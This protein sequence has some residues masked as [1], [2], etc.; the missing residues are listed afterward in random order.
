MVDRWFTGLDA[1][2]RLTL[3]RFAVIMAVVGVLSL[4]AGPGAQMI[5]FTAMTGVAVAVSAALAMAARDEF[6]APSLNRW[7]E[8]LAYIAVSILAI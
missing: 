1:Q 3:R 4:F 8:T 2:S 6:N 7:D 5:F